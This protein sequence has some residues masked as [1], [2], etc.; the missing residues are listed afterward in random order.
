MMEYANLKRCQFLVLS[1]QFSVPG[2]D[3]GN[4]V[5]EPPA[6]FVA[7]KTQRHLIAK[8]GAPTAREL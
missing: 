6:I 4:L 5:N 7:A 8:G 2:D 3:F 1:C